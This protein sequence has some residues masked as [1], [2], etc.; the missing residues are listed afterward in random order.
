M[1]TTPLQEAII[2]IF[3]ALPVIYYAA[4]YSSMPEI[5][6]VH[7][8]AQ[9]VADRM[10]SKNELMAVIAVLTVPMYFLFKYLPKLDPKNQ[11]ER[12]GNKFYVMRL[13]LTVFM[14]LIALGI[15]YTTVNYD[16]TS[17]MQPD[18]VFALVGLLFI[19]L[20]NFMPAM[21][22]NYF[23]GIRTPWTLENEIV[24]RKTHRL[25]AWLFMGSGFATILSALLFSSQT[26]FYVLMG[27]TFAMLGVVMIYSY[28]EFKKQTS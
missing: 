28:T 20:G 14:S 18:W 1:K 3:A 6:P 7:F 10:G 19:V 15:T 23:V 26:T 22:P 21:K 25:G 16:Q 24:W 8:N 27:T 5:V 17:S 9:G 13:A 11:L 12:M 2:I 4:M